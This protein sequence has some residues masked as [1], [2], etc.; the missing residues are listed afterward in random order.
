MTDNLDDFTLAFLEAALWS[1]ID[2]GGEP[3][4]NEHSIADIDPGSLARLA[5]E[6]KRFRASADMASRA[7]RETIRA[8]P[9]GGA[10]VAPSSKARAL[11]SG[12]RGADMARGFGMVTGRNHTPRLSMR[13][14]SS[15][16]TWI[17]TLPMMLR[18]T[19]EA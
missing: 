17:C 18:F 11:I 13:C 4:D 16:A 15:S 14:Q 7:C 19:P 1:S 12:L 10:T 6:C 5:E 8:Q 9:I 3:L 2:D